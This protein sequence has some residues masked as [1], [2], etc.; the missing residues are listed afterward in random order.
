MNFSDSVYVLLSKWDALILIL[1]QDPDGIAQACTRYHALHS[2]ITS[3][4]QEYDLRSDDVI[5]LL[6]SF[7]EDV[8]DVTVDDD[9]VDTVAEALVDCFNGGTVAKW[10][11]LSRNDIFMARPE[12]QPGY[13]EKLEAEMASEREKQFHDQCCVIEEEVQEQVDDDG[14]TTVTKKRGKK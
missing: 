1:K 4:F 11:D 5:S 6:M 7:L 10:C 12:F 2:A 13:I 3:H 8:W 9:S 14:W